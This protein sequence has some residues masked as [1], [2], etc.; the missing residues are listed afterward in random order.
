M[1]YEILGGSRYTSES[2]HVPSAARSLTNPC[3]FGVAPDA[4]VKIGLT[5]ED[6][7]RNSRENHGKTIYVDGLVGKIYA[8]H[9]QTIDFPTKYAG[10]PVNCPSNQSIENVTS[11][12]NGRL[13]GFFISELNLH[14]TGGFSSYICTI[15][16]RQP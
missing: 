15:S 7:S 2:D 10:F 3:C 4:S 12:V 5:K 8:Q 13:P 9:H 11:S 1:N 16:L 14:S 6:I